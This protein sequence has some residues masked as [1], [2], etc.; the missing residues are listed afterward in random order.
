[1]AGRL[2]LAPEATSPADARLYVTHWTRTWG[3]RALIP[4]AALLTSELATN[5]VLHAR[6]RFCVEVSNTGHGIRVEVTDPSDEPVRLQPP[7]EVADHGRGLL[8]VDAVA[9][10]W[11]SHPVADGNGDGEGGKAV[12]FELDAPGA[13]AAS[14]PAR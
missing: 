5:A 6:G 8:V 10:A 13:F 1:M 14:A 2:E 12:W 3:Y 11:G 7:A 4:S 9:D